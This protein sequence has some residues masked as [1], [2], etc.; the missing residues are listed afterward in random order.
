MKRLQTILLTCFI[1]FLPVLGQHGGQNSEDGL[2]KDGYDLWLN[3]D[4]VE[5]EALRDHYLS[6]FA[7]IRVPGSSETIRVIKNELSTAYKGLFNTT[8]PMDNSSASG[9][10]LELKLLNEESKAYSR[11]ESLEREGYSIVSDDKRHGLTIEAPTEA[12]L[13]YGTFHLLRLLQNREP[14]ANLHITEE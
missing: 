13:L 7:D 9:N 1:S 11:F 10:Y 3:Y 12:G 8:L 2:A 14:I 5:S 4:Y 6:Y